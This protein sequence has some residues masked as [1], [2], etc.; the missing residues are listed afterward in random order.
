MQDE[1]GLHRLDAVRVKA[2]QALDGLPDKGK[3]RC[4]SLTLAED[5]LTEAHDVLHSIEH[6]IVML[7]PSVQDGDNFG[8][9]V[10]R[11]VLTTVSEWRESLRSDLSS[12]P[13]YYLQRGTVVEKYATDVVSEEEENGHAKRRRV[14][15]RTPPEDIV[16]YMETLDR[17]CDSMLRMIFRGVGF[18]CDEVKDSVS[19]NI[20]KVRYPR[21]RNV[22]SLVM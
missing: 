1:F 6:A 7:T 13:T 21:C 17:Q 11:T 15:R 20:G 14:E 5:V 9:E 8:V 3:K 10:Q 2:E 22:S 4:Q 12:L 16:R 19:K 18:M